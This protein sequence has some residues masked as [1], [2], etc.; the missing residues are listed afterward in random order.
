[1]HNC[2][3]PF[4]NES[5]TNLPLAFVKR[6]ERAGAEEGQMTTTKRAHSKTAANTRPIGTHTH[7]HRLECKYA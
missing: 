3:P 6:K 7:T 4:C 1:M 2:Q 5:N